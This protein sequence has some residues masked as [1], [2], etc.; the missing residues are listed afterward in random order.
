MEM[1]ILKR[2]DLMEMFGW[3]ETKLWRLE[4]SGKLPEGNRK[5]G[6]PMWLRSDI[7]ALFLQKA[8]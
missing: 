5:L 2:K 7:E 4:K 8:A 1:E 6:Q 3:S